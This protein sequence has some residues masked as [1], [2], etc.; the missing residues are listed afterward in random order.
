MYLCTVLHSLTE[1][2]VALPSRVSYSEFSVVCFVVSSKGLKTMLHLYVEV[3]NVLCVLKF[4]LWY[5]YSI[6][7]YI[8]IPDIKGPS[9]Q[10]RFSQKSYS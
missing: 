1:A 9:H 6:I 3:L 5:L 4:F 8:D 7:V 2:D 10:I